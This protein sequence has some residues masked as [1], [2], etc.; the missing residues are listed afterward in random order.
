MHG[1]AGSTPAPAARMEGATPGLATGSR[2]SRTPCR[3][4]DACPFH[5]AGAC[6]YLH[7]RPPPC[8]DEG[9]RLLEHYVLQA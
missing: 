4:G 5:A 9:T 7:E 6:H 3:C 2:S 8:P 1:P